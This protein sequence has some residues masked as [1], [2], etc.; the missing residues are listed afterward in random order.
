MT[1]A[2][3]T[4]GDGVAESVVALTNVTPVS[5]NLV[6]GTLASLGSV[7]LPGT[8]FPLACCGGIATV[9]ATTTFTAGDNNVFGPFTR[10]AA[11]AF[12]MGLRAPVVISISPSDGNCSVGQDT[13]ITGACFTF[14]GPSGTVTN[15]TRVF[16]VERN[17]ANN[18]K[19]ATR[20]VILG[21]TLIDAFFEFGTVNAG[22]TFLIFVSGPN[23]TSRNLSALPAGAPANCPLGNEQGVQVTFTC[24]T[25]TTPDP[26]GGADLAVLTAC[27]LDRLSSGSFQLT[28]TGSNLKE[29]VQ[30]SVGGRTPK[31]VKLADLQ[32]G[33][34]TFNRAKLKGGFC[35]G[36]PGAIVATNPG[37]RPS[38]ALQC[39][40]TCQ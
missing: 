2:C 16:A 3:D 1:L 30:F 21:S 12:D 37:A 28:V 24:S 17:N 15:V 36:L 29:G 38:T 39:S 19:D 34:N 27:T 40:A 22:K 7:G 10:S 20:F 23:G 11:C 5:K 13:I 14:A 4:N 26:P 35:G 9:T 25:A 31:K 8:A 18:V 32:T 6:R 33:S